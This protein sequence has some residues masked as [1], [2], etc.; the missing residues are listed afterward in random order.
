MGVVH[1]FEPLETDLVRLS[2]CLRVLFHTIL[3]S[4]AF[5]TL[6][7]REVNCDLI[8]VS[9]V[10]CEDRQVEKKVETAI[11][12]FGDSIP[13]KSGSPIRSF[14]KL[15]FFESKAKRSFFGFSTNEERVNWE[16]WCFPL[17]IHCDPSTVGPTDF[18]AKVSEQLKSHV[19][20]IIKL[21]NVDRDMPSVNMNATDLIFPFDISTTG[22][23]EADTSGWFSRLVKTGPPSVN[24]GIF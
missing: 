7:P 17:V 1:K 2:D 10:M 8:D 12:N 21:V 3:F 9:Y 13:T 24:D 16:E 22:P 11:T 14:V 18:N 6:K 5:G 15:S 4:R 20:K 19:L 23:Q